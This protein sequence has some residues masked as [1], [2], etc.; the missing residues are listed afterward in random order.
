MIVII[1]V[2]IWFVVAAAAAVLSYLIGAKHKIIKLGLQIILAVAIVFLAIS[3]YNGIMEPI[4]FKEARDVRYKAAVKEL[5][6][7]RKAEVAYKKEKGKYTTSYDTLIKFVRYDSITDILKN[8]EV[9]D[10]IFKE[11]KMNR[12]KA[13]KLAIKRGIIS[14][15]TVRVSTLDSLFKNYDIEKLG[16]VPFTENEMFEIDT[17]TIETSGMKLNVFEARVKNIILLN[18]LNRQL[19]LNLNDDQTKS[20]DGEEDNKKF[21]GL[22][23][24][25]ITENN[26]NEGNW[27]KVYEIGIKGKKKKKKKKK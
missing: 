20:S 3:L 9:P 2:I 10:S 26:N 16:R 18:G 14:R 15:D 17:A 22:K 13:E 19:I 25:S 24:G 23:V 4:K 1:K 7:I 8:G 21:A 11:V 6:N 27:S 12:K 5:I